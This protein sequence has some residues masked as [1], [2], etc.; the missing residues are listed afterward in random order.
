MQEQTHHPHNKKKAAGIAGAI[1]GAGVAIAAAKILSDKKNREKI[2]TTY[3]DMKGKVMESIES[4]QDDKKEPTQKS[5]K[6]IKAR[7]KKTKTIQKK[8]VDRPR[9]AKGH[10]IKKNESNPNPPTPS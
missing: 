6:T 7:P 3:H 10:F 1:I 2:K 5:S 4:M 8:Q 9:D